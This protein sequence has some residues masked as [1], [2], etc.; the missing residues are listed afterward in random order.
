MSPRGPQAE[1]SALA[2][3]LRAAACSFTPRTG[4]KPPTYSRVRRHQSALSSRTTAI[5]TAIAADANVAATPATMS[6]VTGSGTVP[7]RA[8]NTATN[9]APTSTTAPAVNAPLIAAV[10]TIHA[11]LGAR[12]NA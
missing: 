3:L 2:A 9:D 11:S 6:G 4:G 7:P 1:R 5:G 12:N 10:P 8:T